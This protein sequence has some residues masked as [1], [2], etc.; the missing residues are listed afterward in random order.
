MSGRLQVLLAAMLFSTAGVV[1]KAT[2]LTSWQIAGFRSAVAAVFL[3]LVARF[4]LRPTWRTL[5][6]GLFIAVTF[7]TF[8]VAN[9]QTTAAH[10][11]FLQAAAPLYLVLL[12]PWLLAERVHAR[13]IPFLCVVFVGLG[14][15]FAGTVTPSA[16]APNPAFGNIIG[17]VSGVTWALVLA[18]V[19]LISRA[20]G[21]KGAM[22]ATFYGNV[23]AFLLCAPVAFPVRA[24]GPIDWAVIAY[25]GCFQLA[26]AY[27]LL[28]R[29]IGKLP[30]LEAALLLLLEPALNPLWTFLVHGETP[31]IV[32][33]IGGG[34]VLVATTARALRPQGVER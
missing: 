27:V 30:A 10:A 15:L 22:A 26:L 6:V 12:G 31:G 21:L 2:V 24:A 16:T 4:P 34:L 33:S 3:L 29:G 9:K 32:G 7:I 13:D 19:R 8:I 14:L 20:E 18:G 5:S 28:T 17:A 23:F 11:V 25:L 1:V